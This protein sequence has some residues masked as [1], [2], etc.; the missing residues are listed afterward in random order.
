MQ[1][2]P[3]LRLRLRE[4]LAN[5]LEELPYAEA[6]PSHALLRKPSVRISLLVGI[7]LRP[8]SEV[9][10][11]A[12]DFDEIGSAATAVGAE[13][14]HE[15]DD[16]VGESVLEHARRG[17]LRHARSSPVVL[18]VEAKVE[19]RHELRKR[20]SQLTKSERRRRRRTRKSSRGM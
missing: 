7:L 13:V 15:R 12:R 14:S 18:L 1:C 19:D 5:R 4:R 16:N 2:P 9:P 20:K 10:R 3:R 17:V 8:T 6:V 11:P